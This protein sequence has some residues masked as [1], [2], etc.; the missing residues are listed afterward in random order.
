[1]GYS[2]SPSL[3]G[4]CVM[5]ASVYEVLPGDGCLA[6]YALALG[7][8]DGYPPAAIACGCALELAGSTSTLMI[9]SFWLRG[10][11]GR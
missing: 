11:G 7:I 6:M 5:G 9:V 1:M 4:G 2:D 3:V 8:S 10:I